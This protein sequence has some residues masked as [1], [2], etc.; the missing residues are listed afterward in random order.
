MKEAGRPIPPPSIEPTER[1]SAK[2]RIRAL[3]SPHRR[4]AEREA[5][6]PNTLAVALLAE[7]LGERAAHGN[8]NRGCPIGHPV[9]A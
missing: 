2:W 5:A 6:A 8:L 7:D 4:F 1:Y 9:T 3:R